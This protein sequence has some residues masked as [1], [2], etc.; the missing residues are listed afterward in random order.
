[1]PEKFKGRLAV[2]FTDWNRQGRDGHLFFN[3]QDQS[4]IGPHQSG[5]WLVF[6]LDEQESKTHEYTL[7]VDRISGANLMMT[8]IAVLGMIA[9]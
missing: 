2:H 5:R 8:D 3:G 4:L 6:K 1:M 7:K 9:P